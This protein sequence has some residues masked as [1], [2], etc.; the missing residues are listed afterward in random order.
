MNMIELRK[1]LKSKKPRFRMTGFGERKRVKDKWRHAGG[2]D[3]KIKK[4]F[5]GYP[6]KVRI[7]YGSPR[8]AKGMHPSGL[9]IA[10]INNV[11]ELNDVD[12]KIQGVYISRTVSKKKKLEIIKKCGELSVKILNFKNPEEWVK[13][14]SEEIE[15]R[16]EEKKKKGEEKEKKKKEKEKKVAEKEKKEAKE[17]GKEKTEEGLAEKIEEAKEKEEKEKQ[18]VLTKKE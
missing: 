4:G 11:N 3:N 1:N 17:E 6:K 7:G 2:S 14:I 5:K 16:K 18:K 15:A 9:S 10:V 12:P 8:A 13:K